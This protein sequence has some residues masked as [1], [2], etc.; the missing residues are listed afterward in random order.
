MRFFTLSSFCVLV[1]CCAFGSCSVAPDEALTA[2][3]QEAWYRD[4]FVISL[5]NIKSR[6]KQSGS[7]VETLFVVKFGESRKKVV[8][9]IDRRTKRVILESFDEDGHRTSEHLNVASL[10]PDTPLK[11]I[12]ILVQQRPQHSQVGIYVDCHFQ[13]SIP[14]NRCFRELAETE[15]EK[16][17]EA[18]RERRSRVKV[19][20]SP[21][22]V[23][24]LKEEHC[25]D[26][27]LEL[28][29]IFSRGYNETREDRIKTENR[30]RTGRHFS[31]VK[32]EEEEDDDDYDVLYD[33]RSTR[34]PS[35]YPVNYRRHPEMPN[36]S[37]K[38][39][40]SRVREHQ[41]ERHSQGG[42]VE[43]G[44]P[45]QTN[46]DY[47]RVPRRGDISIQS[48]DERNCMTDNQIVKTLNELIAALK[49]VWREI[50]LNRLE[51]QHLRQLIENCA[52]C[53]VPVG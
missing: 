19:Y 53:R 52:G 33:N 2:S 10:T 5:S 49:T 6:K 14:M 35:Q 7:L 51:T 18:L 12:I 3:L 41:W 28:D 13:G 23:D 43:P 47:K 11:N 27:L 22:V 44:Y 25:P 32:S 45:N 24:A 4:D 40:P 26:N 21:S 42:S 34:R 30:K 9:M 50:E 16:F 39:S 31:T 36:Y 1:L 17:A 20:Q 46:L 37:V 15:D 8:L 48:L 29:A 38:S